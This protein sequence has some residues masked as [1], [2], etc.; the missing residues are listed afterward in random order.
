MTQNKI[1]Q[2]IVPQG[3][4]R[5]FTT[6]NGKLFVFDKKTKQE[7]TTGTGNVANE[8][9]FYDL[10]SQYTNKI[11]EDHQYVENRLAKIEGELLPIIGAALIRVQRYKM[12]KPIKAE[13]KNKLTKFLLIQFLRTRTQRD[14]LREIIKY[15]EETVPSKRILYTVSDAV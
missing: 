2:H 11:G 8:R 15:A 10:P 7:F 13:H 6:T 4:L 9:F 1:K 3:Y 14:V 5:N 12:R